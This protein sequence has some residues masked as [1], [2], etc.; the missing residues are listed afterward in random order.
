MYNPSLLQ[1][2]YSIRTSCE[3][4][5]K[6]STV[7]SPVHTS[8]HH[9]IHPARVDL[10]VANFP[11]TLRQSA[12][13]LLIDL[14]RYLLPVYLFTSFDQLFG[15]LVRLAR[16]TLFARPPA[17]LQRLS[18]PLIA[19]RPVS[20]LSVLCSKCFLMEPFFTITWQFA[21]GNMTILQF[22]LC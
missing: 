19:S 15:Y 20:V 10:R 17:G 9:C 12:R 7:V 8:R 22:G 5:S 6:V 13:A 1:Y 14:E 18:G 2:T 4:N 21:A 16:S 3:D 11:H